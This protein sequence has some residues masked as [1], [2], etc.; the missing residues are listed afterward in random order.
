M[1]RSIFCAFLFFA[2]IFLSSCSDDASDKQ[3]SPTTN[4]SVSSATASTNPSVAEQKRSDASVQGVK[5]KVKIMSESLIPGEGSKKTVSKN[6]FKY[7]ANGNMTELSNY[8]ADGKLSSTIK[9]TYDSSGK[10]VKEETFLGNGNSDFVSTVKTDAKGNKIEQQ[11]VRPM[12]NIMFNYRHVYKY[13][14]KGQLIERVAF[15]GNGSLA[16]KYNFTYDDRGNRI[17]WLQ[18]G[19][20]NTIIGKVAYKFN[21]N[22]NV[23]EEAKFKADGTSEAI[24]TYTYDYD[25]KNNW[26]RQK[27]T[28]EGKVIEIKEREYNYY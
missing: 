12:G 15:R 16:F 25:K 3:D 27:K 19:P 6:V 7:D 13:D 23:V 28:Q 21:E 4:E 10:L 26:I 20:S 2:A 1:K 17:E 22:K 9:Y 8:K 24:Y 14:E 5:G 18:T 11:D